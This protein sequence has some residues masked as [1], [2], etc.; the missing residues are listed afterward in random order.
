MCEETNIEVN[1]AK[2]I[3]GA[4]PLF[5]WDIAASSPP[6]SVCIKVDFFEDGSV[7]LSFHS[8]YLGSICL[9]AYIIAMWLEKSS[10]R[11]E[12]NRKPLIWL[13]SLAYF[14]MKTHV[15]SVVFSTRRSATV[16]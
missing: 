12:G 14:P 7:C 4:R 9:K 15:T 8:G 13:W 2:K 1:A 11:P 3:Q 6:A 16:R 10:R 5:H